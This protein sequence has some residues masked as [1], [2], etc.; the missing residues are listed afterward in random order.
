VQ[1]KKKKKKNCVAVL[2]IKANQLI[3]LSLYRAPIGDFHLFIK[4]LDDTLKYLY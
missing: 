4:D 2:E 3:I 1:K